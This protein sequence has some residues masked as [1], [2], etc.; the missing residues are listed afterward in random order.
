MLR[1]AICGIGALG[2]VLAD[3]IVKKHTEDIELFGIVRDLNSC[4]CR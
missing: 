4:W 1:I 2:S 3:K